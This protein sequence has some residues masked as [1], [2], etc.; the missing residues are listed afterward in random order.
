[1]SLQKTSLNATN[2][3]NIYYQ[4]KNTKTQEFLARENNLGIDI[5]PED[6]PI[7]YSNAPDDKY[8]IG[9]I[10]NTAPGFEAY[11]LSVEDILSKTRNWKPLF[12]RE[13]RVEKYFQKGDSIYYLTSKNATN[14]KIC[15]TSI[16][17]PN[18]EN[19]IEVAVERIDAVIKDMALTKRGTFYTT[20]KNGVV[21]K[22]FYKPFGKKEIE[23]ELPFAAGYIRT[24]SLGVGKDYIS[25]TLQGW[26]HPPSKYTFNYTDKRLVKDTEI[27]LLYPQQITKDIEE[28]VIEEFEVPAKDGELVPLS[29]V[30]NKNLKKDGSTSVIMRG[31][32]AYGSS[33]PPV[34]DYGFL[35]PALEGGIYAVAHV[36]GGGEK[37]D[38]WYK[39]GY[40][41]T[42]SNTWND[43]IACSEYLVNQKYTSNGKLAI[44]SGSAG[45]ILIGRAITQRPD[46][47]GAAIIDNGYLNPSRHTVAINGIDTTYEFGSV[48]KDD[49]VEFVKE[50][51]SFLHVKNDT[52]YPASLIRASMNDTRVDPFMSIKFAAKLQNSTISDAPI[53]LYPDFD[54]GHLYS[55]SSAKAEYIRMADAIA[56][57]YW[58]TGHPKYQLRQK[59]K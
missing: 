27:S 7:V 59:E 16:R 44:W 3:K 15:K 57:A 20:I 39:A 56:F 9:A 48:E 2:V 11:S 26:L 46:L 37:G 13:E 31:Y 51:D 42:K 28:L 25:F 22:L 4:L 34:F 18:F 45:G 40:K 14:F 33:L 55:L 1:M 38:R 21:G 43:F 6:F 53:L 23:V 35:L 52:A 5:K 12:T 49:E 8:C 30:Y 17:T 50:M 10:Y 24:Y 58:Q 32:G 47:Y 41:E 36:R 29:L 54:R 19:P